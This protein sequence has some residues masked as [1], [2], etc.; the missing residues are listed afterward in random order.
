[1]STLRI[2]LFLVSFYFFNISL[3]FFLLQA[4]LFPYLPCH[5]L[6]LFCL[7]PVPVFFSFF[8]FPFISQHYTFFFSITTR[9]NFYSYY[10]SIFHFFSITTIFF[11]FLSCHPS[12]LFFSV[13]RLHIFF[14]VTFYF[15]KFLYTSSHYSQVFLFPSFPQQPLPL[16][17]L[18]PVSIFFV[19]FSFIL[20]ISLHLF[21]LQLFFFFYLSFFPFLII[22]ASVLSV[23]GLL[24]PRL[25]K[26]TSIHL[27]TRV[28]PHLGGGGGGGIS[29]ISARS[30]Q[31]K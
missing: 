24:L 30:K 23:T 13:S 19:L 29:V 26:L 18:Y 8:L 7:S 16:F 12:L 17:F 14:L 5:P 4:V 11:F 20:N 27:K 1:M 25:L 10:F 22:L 3:D 2:F 9:V 21:P 15:S 31:C 6:P 28:T